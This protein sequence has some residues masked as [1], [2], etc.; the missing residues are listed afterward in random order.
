MSNTTFGVEIEVILTLPTH[1]NNLC[2]QHQ[3]LSGAMADPFAM[4]LPSLKSIIDAG[5][6]VKRTQ[7]DNDYTKWVITEDTSLFNPLRGLKVGYEFVSP[8]LT[9]DAGINDLVNKVTLI[10]KLNVETDY[11]TGLH[12]HMS[13]EKYSH[14]EISNIIIGFL[15]FEGQFDSLISPERRGDYSATAR[16]P[17]RSA[18]LYFSDET[19]NFP[20]L[21][22]LLKDLSL[23][24]LVNAVN[25]M[26]TSIQQSCRYH[27]LNL[28]HLFKPESRIEYRL[29]EGATDPT[30]IKCWVQLLESFMN[31]AAKGFPYPKDLLKEVG[32]EV[33]KTFSYKKLHLS[34]TRRHTDPDRQHVALR[35]GRKQSR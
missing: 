30:E 19:L 13:C 3:I 12:V 8:K 10:E 34:A 22:P 26:L 31:I 33:E 24:D 27:K 23:R 1:N 11:Q 7:Q 18:V 17:L 28:C 14:R 6:V 4:G 20:S 21:Y 16:S 32:G 2:R 29:H 35:D 25:P 9:G 15:H 5:F